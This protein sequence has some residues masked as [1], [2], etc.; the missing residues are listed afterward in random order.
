MQNVALKERN[1]AWMHDAE[2]FLEIHK[3]E[4]P[5][6]VSGHALSSLNRQK[7]NKVELLPCTSDLMKVLTY[8][9]NQIEIHLRN[10]E[11]EPTNETWHQLEEVVL[12]QVIIFNKRRAGEVSR[13]STVD[14]INRHKWQASAEEFRAVLSSLEKQ[15]CE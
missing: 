12:A 9:K 5:R 13:T 6:R 8:I 3:Y 4:W 1:S 14:Y 15:L 7:R 2:A 10:M 11:S